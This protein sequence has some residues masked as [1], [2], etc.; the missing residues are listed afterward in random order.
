MKMKKSSRPFV[1]FY[2][3]VAY[4]CIQF[5]WW[6]YMLYDLNKELFELKTNLALS[7]L[8]NMNLHEEISHN[9]QER[10]NK[11]WLMILG[12]GTVFL[13]LLLLGVL[14]FRKSI[15]KELKLAEQQKNFLLSITHE[16]KSPIASAVL[17]LQT[18]LKRTLP[19]EKQSEIITT[20][21]EDLA[22]LNSLT[23]NL[24]IAAR[25]ED[26]SY[27][28]HKEKV[29]LSEFIG[30]TLKKKIN[31][32]ISVKLSLAKGINLN[33]DKLAFSSVIIN[34]F[35]NAVKYSPQG[36]NIIIEGL[37][38]GENLV[39]RFKDEGIGIPEE[40]AKDIFKKFFRVGNEETRNAKGTGLGLFIA[41]QII[42][43]HNGEINFYPNSP[44]GSIFEIKLALL[45]E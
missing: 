28:L 38:H 44:K 33:I 14:K 40:H 12:E 8:D 31:E 19:V 25:I 42:E 22:R 26:S 5:A 13:L 3:L 17:Q 43:K 9:N 23:D 41:R 29:E 18:I 2:I 16:L 36:S 7:L 34:L 4:I 1:I 11:R 39:L 37:I 45:N 10:L 27:N 24:L 35:E 6:A 20:A 30:Q 32:N 21:L 15:L